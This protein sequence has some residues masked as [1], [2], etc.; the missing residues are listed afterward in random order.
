M[1]EVK[2]LCKDVQRSSCVTI[3][4]TF[5]SKIVTANYGKT[6]ELQEDVMTALAAMKYSF[7]CFKRKQEVITTV[8]EYCRKG[9]EDFHSVFLQAVNDFFPN[10]DICTGLVTKDYTTRDDVLKELQIAAEKKGFYSSCSLNNKEVKTTTCLNYSSLANN[11]QLTTKERSR[12][13]Q[14]CK[15]IVPTLGKYSRTENQRHQLSMKLVT[16]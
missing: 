3:I 2:A 5:L 15:A 7:S 12:L 4:D 1:G 8:S 14:D 10:S 6:L 11:Y 16:N 9:N 13:F